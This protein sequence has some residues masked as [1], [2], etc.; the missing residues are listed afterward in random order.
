[1]TLGAIAPSHT[2]RDKTFSERMIFHA[3]SLG[4]THRGAVGSW[5]CGQGIRRARETEFFWDL[6][7]KNYS[8]LGINHPTMLAPI[9]TALWKTYSFANDLT[10][11]YPALSGWQWSVISSKHDWLKNKNWD[12]ASAWELSS[13]S[14]NLWEKDP[15]LKT[16]Q[17]W[18]GFTHLDRMTHWC[19][20]IDEDTVWCASKNSLPS[21]DLSMQEK[22]QWF[23]PF[24][25]AD[26][27]GSD[28]RLAEL[29]TLL[30]DVLRPDERQGLNFKFYNK[31]AAKLAELGL[32]C[33]GMDNNI[34]C[35]FPL[36]ILHEDI[37][38]LR[39]L[40]KD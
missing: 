13:P 38:G 33:D 12:F 24:L 19:V 3:R 30:S 26:A 20:Q 29:V 11:L 15:T 37:Q 23:R 5:L 34:L 31:N 4:L 9:E 22:H 27:L 32:S 40:L 21:S 1:M 35:Y 10:T 39:S 2:E 16:D 18:L 6:T 7:L 14:E 28:G 17:G 25:S 36:S 8:P